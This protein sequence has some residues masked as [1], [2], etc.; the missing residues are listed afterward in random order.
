MAAPI[1]ATHPELGVDINGYT[2]S[3]PDACLEVYEWRAGSNV[4]HPERCSGSSGEQWIL[5]NAAEIRWGPDPSLCLQN[6]FNW[7]LSLRPCNGATNQ[8][9]YRTWPQYWFHW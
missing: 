8:I 9:W 1:S 2:S 5:S 3:L 7:A 4:V 6:D